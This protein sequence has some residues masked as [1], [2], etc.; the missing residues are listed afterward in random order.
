VTKN[1]EKWQLD[2]YGQRR[3]FSGRNREQREVVHEE[4][5][6][7]LEELHENGEQAVELTNDNFQEFLKNFDMAFIDMY[8]P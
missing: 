7:S 2:E 6:E 8:A 4:H 1:V 3:I 5:E